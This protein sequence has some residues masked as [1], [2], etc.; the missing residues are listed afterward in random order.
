MDKPSTISYYEH[1]AQ[2]ARSEA[3]AKRWAVAALIIFIALIGTNAGWL[4]YES[5]YHDV[6]TV[7]QEAESEG[8]IYQNGTGSMN[9]GEGKAEGN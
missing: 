8:A 2:V 1:E 5:Q 9:V 3:N 4:V 6:V 7:E